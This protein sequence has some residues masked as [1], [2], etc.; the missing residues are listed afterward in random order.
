MAN[1]NITGLVS[2]H[3]CWNSSGILPRRT[4]E[5]LPGQGNR[6]QAFDLW[7]GDMVLESKAALLDFITFDGLVRVITYCSLPRARPG[8]RCP[9]FATTNLMPVTFW[10]LV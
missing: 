3:V 9:C 5:R 6:V 7:L 4:G 1:K 8:R 10:S 2:Q